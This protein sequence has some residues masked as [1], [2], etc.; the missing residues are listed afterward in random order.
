MSGGRGFSGRLPAPPP[1]LP[2]GELDTV[3]G[4][5]A[6]SSSVRD[7]ATDPATA[8]GWVRRRPTSAGGAASG[9]PVGAQL[10]AMT[11]SPHSAAGRGRPR[12]DGMPGAGRP[13]RFGPQTLATSS[14]MAGGQVGAPFSEHPSGSV[15]V[16]TQ[17]APGAHRAPVGRPGSARARIVVASTASLAGL[18]A[19]V[20]GVAITAD[21]NPAVIADGGPATSS[22]PLQAAASTTDG[23]AQASRGIDRTAL[24]VTARTTPAAPGLGATRTTGSTGSSGGLD[25]GGST[26]GSIP[27]SGGGS[28]ASPGGLSDGFQIPVV[29]LQTSGSTA[30]TSSGTG[31]GSTSGSTRPTAPTTGS[32]TGPSTT[33]SSSPSS[34]PTDGQSGLPAPSTDDPTPTSST[35]NPNP[36]PTGSPST[37]PD[38]GSGSLPFDPTPP[39]PGT[40]T[41]VTLTPSATPSPSASPASSGWNY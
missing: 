15:H 32:T 2:P 34:T 13:T 3:T 17:R 19:L 30:G 36:T 31:S 6:R 38:P 40:I 1:H 41:V 25:A 14:R 12:A 26:S 5:L 27:Q 21:A 11:G 4:P 9:A 28:V 29:T 33:P 16:T 18:S 8:Y 24:P 22:I 7:G 39:Q 35:P 37:S 20:A 10:S 23:G